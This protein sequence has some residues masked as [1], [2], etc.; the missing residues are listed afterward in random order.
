MCLWKKSDSVVCFEILWYL[1]IATR[2]DGSY[3]TG[4]VLFASRTRRVEVRFT[5]DW[6]IGRK[7]F[8]LDV[9]ADSCSTVATIPVQPPSPTCDNPEEVHV[10]AGETREGA[11]V[12]YTQSDGTYPNHM[13]QAWTVTTDPGQV[14]ADIWWW[15][16]PHKFDS[17]CSVYLLR[18]SQSL[19]AFTGCPIICTDTYSQCYCGHW[20]LQPCLTQSSSLVIRDSI[21]SGK[22]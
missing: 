9:R 7:G 2:R 18:N 17:T 14:S 13:C 19:L 16:H 20:H 12:S 15:G 4:D 8:S 10:A 3:M 5:S 21:F 11:L 1:L 6:C 22:S